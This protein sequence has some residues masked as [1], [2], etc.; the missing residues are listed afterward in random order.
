MGIKETLGKIENFVQKECLSDIENERLQANLEAVYQRLE[1][2]DYQRFSYSTNVFDVQNRVQ[3]IFTDLEF[4]SY[5]GKTWAS[6]LSELKLE[7]FSK[8]LDICP[9]YSPKI[10]L[11]LYYLGYK[12]KLIVLDKDK[13]SFCFLQKFTDLFNVGY[14]MEA[15]FS[16][17]F[18]KKDEQYELVV[19]N[20]VLDDLTVD[21]FAKKQGTSLK[22]IY[23][24]EQEMIKIWNY[25]LKDK[26]QNME[27]IL[28]L[29]V[30]SFDGFVKKG[31]Y[32]CLAQYKSYMEKM[33]GMEE[34]S[35]FNKDLFEEVVSKLTDR[36]FEI[37]NHKVKNAFHKF[38]GH[39]GPDDFVI[40]RK[41]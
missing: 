35:K 10:E 36:D 17:F 23:A 26:K 9:G 3:D 41:K 27:E 11:G 31:G 2:R 18:E 14:D 30:N 40:L 13:Q 24:N 22:D 32:F 29:L 38:N 20:H 5:L 19:A 15:K 1:K 37:V 34:T 33:L 25:I 21:Y 16:D 6:I 12:G 8:I 39:F 7:N 28:P 4:Y